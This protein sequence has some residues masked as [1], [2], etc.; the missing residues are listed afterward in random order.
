M[1]F[2][3]SP[4]EFHEYLL[5]LFAALIL[6][7]TF[8]EPPEI[9]H[10]SVWFGKLIG[11]FD[12]RWKR[13]GKVDFVVG[14][15]ATIVVVLFAF[16]LFLPIIFLIYPF[17]LVWATYL[18]YS[19]ISL[20]SMVIHAKRTFENGFLDP[21]KVQ[22]IV[23]RDTSRLNE[24]QLTSAVIESIAEN[25]VDGVLAP[26]FYF[27]LFGVVGAIVYR[28][29]NICDAMVGYKN[30]KYYY[31]GKF[32]ARL[33]DLV[34]FIPSRL[35][36]LLFSILS[37]KALKHALNYKIKLNGHPIAAM[38]GLLGVKIEKPGKYIIDG[39]VAEIK[40]IKKCIK[41]YW[42]LCIIAIILVLFI[43]LLKFYVNI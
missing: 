9:I 26:L 24:G 27:S 40:D 3:V 14:F 43:L 20:K 7:L 19:S 22:M 5:V 35:S 37:Y 12:L 4:F 10:P 39:K 29:I 2:S 18:L 8:A 38:A 6:D 33:D 36:V 34:N 11:F 25:F 41:Y 32:A 15:V 16:I 31:F 23:S 1:M 13:K 17:N 30:D 42:V 28:A 21:K